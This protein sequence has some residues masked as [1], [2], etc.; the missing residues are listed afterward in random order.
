[1]SK[2]LLFTGILS[3][4]VLAAVYT[5]F[6]Q[7]WWGVSK[8][9]RVIFLYVVGFPAISYIYALA[10]SLQTKKPLDECIPGAIIWAIAFSILM[11]I[12]QGFILP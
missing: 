9:V 5:G 1:M 2:W 7:V 12:F 3:T 8:P 6:P 11:I 4:L 10:T